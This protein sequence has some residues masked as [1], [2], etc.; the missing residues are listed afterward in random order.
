[1]VE[2]VPDLIA[3]LDEVHAVLK[4]GAT[5]R[6]AVPDR[7]FTFDFMRR[8]SEVSDVITAHVLRARAPTPGQLIDSCLNHQLVDRRDMWN[9]GAARQPRYSRAERLEHA[10]GCAR[11]VMAQGVY[12]DVHCWVFT[13]LSFARL[14]EQ[15]AALGYVRYACARLFETER[16]E[17]EFFA[18][19]RTSEDRG[20][21]VDSWRSAGDALEAAGRSAE[22]H[23]FGETL[24]QAVEGLQETARRNAEAIARMESRFGALEQRFG[25]LERRAA[26]LVWLARRAW[27]R[28][29]R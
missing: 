11:M 27:G 16:E 15:L 25:A 14:M 6:L 7:R 26:P 10:V 13:P 1:V 29:R 2:H 4:P 17:D 21:C 22:L 28:L 23:A 24:R 8:E 19:L 9:G 18:I 20:E 5:L 12:I 3:W